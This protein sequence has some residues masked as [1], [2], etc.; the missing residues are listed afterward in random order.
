MRIVPIR[1]VLE[2]TF[3]IISSMS[4]ITRLI[5]F[6]NFSSKFDFLR[7]R[8]RITLHFFRLIMYLNF[9]ASFSSTSFSK[10]PLLYNPQSLHSHFLDFW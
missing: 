5:I 1:I 9:L 10:P 4:P 3:S 7:I 2:F 6:Y 8:H